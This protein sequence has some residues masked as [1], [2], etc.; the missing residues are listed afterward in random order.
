MPVNTGTDPVIADQLNRVLLTIEAGG[1]ATLEDGGIPFD[2][3]VTDNGVRLE[4]E[5]LAISGVNIAKQPPDSPRQFVFQKD[6]ENLIFD[7][8]T[9]EKVRS[10]PK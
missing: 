10:L 5:V 7:G 3:A 1:K 2:G 6:G 4:F 8:T 9:L